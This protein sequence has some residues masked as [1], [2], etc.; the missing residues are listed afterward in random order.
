VDADRRG[1]RG[2]AAVELVAIL[3]LLAAALLAVAQ[4]AVAGYALWAAADAA[5]A[6]ARAAHVGGDAVSAAKSALPAWLEETARVDSAGTVAVSVGA[7]ALL[8]SVP[9]LRVAA[10]AGLDP[11]AA[12]G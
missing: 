7:P 2:Q 3:P 12:D 9:D 1:Q 5:R 11:A 6:G 4:L 8:P 10:E